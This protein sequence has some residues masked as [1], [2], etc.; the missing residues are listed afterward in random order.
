[1][2]QFK[3]GAVISIADQEYFF[4]GPHGL[5]TFS[6]FPSRGRS[7]SKFTSAR[8]FHIQDQSPPDGFVLLRASPSP[9]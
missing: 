6:S 1:M 4:C 9:S 7:S 8:M 5:L 2:Q 3:C